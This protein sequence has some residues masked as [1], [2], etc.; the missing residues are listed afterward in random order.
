MGQKLV[1]VLAGHGT[2]L[3]FRS[4]GPCVSLEPRTVA[5]AHAQLLKGQGALLAH[6]L[7]FADDLAVARE[8]GDVHVLGHALRYKRYGIRQAMAF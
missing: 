2:E 4:L 7:R 6:A 8:L 5:E 3:G 1:L